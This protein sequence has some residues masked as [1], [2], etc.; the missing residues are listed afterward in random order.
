MPFNVQAAILRSADDLEH[1][2]VRVSRDL[3]L[4]SEKEVGLIANPPPIPAEFAH[5]PDAG[6]LPLPMLPPLG[7]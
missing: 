4:L 3:D 7:P 2:A 5:A 1:Q 6:L